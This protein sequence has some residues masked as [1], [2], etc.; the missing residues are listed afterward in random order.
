MTTTKIL[1]DFNNLSPV[2]QLCFLSGCPRKAE[3]LRFMAGEHLPEQK[4]HGPAIYPTALQDGR[5]CPF[6]QEKQ[7]KHMAWGF[8]TLFQDTRR[9]DESRLRTAMKKYLG[10]HGTYYCYNRGE[11]L[12]TPEQQ[13][14]ILDLFRKAGYEQNLRFDHYADVYDFDH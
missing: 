1:F 14:W 8:E 4:L 12:L 6:F 7:T 9:R 3:C 2:Y 11:R 10:G 13:E 5:E